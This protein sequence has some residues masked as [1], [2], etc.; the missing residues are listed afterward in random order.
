MGLIFLLLFFDSCI[1]ITITFA[2]LCVAAFILL[3]KLRTKEQ[4]QGDIIP[5]TRETYLRNL[6]GTQNLAVEKNRNLRA[7]N[8]ALDLRKFE[9]ELYWKR[10]RF[11][12]FFIAACFTGIG[13]S[14][15]LQIQEMFV[16]LMSCLGFFMTVAFWAANKGSKFWQENWESH[17][18]LLEEEWV[19]PMYRMVISQYPAGKY[20]VQSPWP[21]SVSRINMTVS[22]FLIFVWLL[23]IIWQIQ[24]ADHERIWRTTL[25]FF[26]Q[27]Y[28]FWS[29]EWFF[30]SHSIMY[31]LTLTS[32]HMRLLFTIFLGTAAYLLQSCQTR[33]IAEIL[34]EAKNNCQ[35][36]GEEK[37]LIPRNEW[38]K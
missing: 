20:G 22:A 2:L 25:F 16:F 1:W 4:V 3:H 38:W 34:Q 35:K 33:E 19:G 28:Y 30:F 32:T 23:V 15:K 31:H 7:W 21:F 24:M 18:D 10:A 8:M 36:A 5:F 9:I 27:P 37:I 6:R 12:W 26:S 13:L 14:D 11:F 29:K 17:V